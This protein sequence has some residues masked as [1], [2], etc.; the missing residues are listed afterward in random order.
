MVS[1]AENNKSNSIYQ[2][3]EIFLEEKKMKTVMFVYR[4]SHQ[5]NFQLAN[6]KNQ[7]LKQ[8]YKDENSYSLFWDKNNYSMTKQI[9]WYGINKD[10]IDNDFNNPNVS[11]YQKFKS[12]SSIDNI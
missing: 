8:L 11:L 1:Y 5:V 9:N 6:K 7:F 2:I 4:T 3:S 10:A 12:F